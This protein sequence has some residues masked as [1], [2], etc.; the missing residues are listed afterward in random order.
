MALERT[1]TFTDTNTESK[2]EIYSGVYFCPDID[3]ELV[4]SETAVIPTVKVIPLTATSGQSIFSTDDTNLTLETNAEKDGSSITLTTSTPSIIE[5]NNT[6]IKLSFKLKNSSIFSIASSSFARTC[7]MSADENFLVLDQIFPFR[8]TAT[9]GGSPENLDTIVSIEC[10]KALSKVRANGL[11]SNGNTTTVLNGLATGSVFSIKLDRFNEASLS[12]GTFYPAHLVDK[13][14]SNMSVW[15]E[16]GNDIPINS[17]ESFLENMFCIR[18]S[19]GLILPSFN[20]PGTIHELLF[21]DPGHNVITDLSP[22]NLSS[23]CD[24]VRIEYEVTDTN[25][26]LSLQGLE[27]FVDAL[28][29]TQAFTHHFVTPGELHFETPAKT[30]TKVFSGISVVEA[31]A[32]IEEVFDEADDI[33]TTVT[34]GGTPYQF[35][36]KPGAFISSSEGANGV[37]IHLLFRMMRLYD[38]GAFLVNCFIVGSDT[39]D[40]TFGQPNKVK[41]DI[42]VDGN[43]NPISSSLVDGDSTF[44]DSY[45]KNRP[46]NMVVLIPVQPYWNGSFK[47]MVEISNNDGVLVSVESRPINISSVNNGILLIQ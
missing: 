20:I 43:R 32:T 27:I 5:S 17:V 2:M 30:T 16:S 7:S 3:P 47:L 9:Y 13:Y 6:S 14:G 25:E 42:Y 21:Y 23:N 33:D 4:N 46:V 39:V 24:Y 1:L 11:D 36:I 31:F 10:K 35:N 34:I 12:V 18:L 37:E 15:D 8:F 45:P 26:L 40:G 19:S 29:V 22:S 41:A 28:D 38:D 44:T